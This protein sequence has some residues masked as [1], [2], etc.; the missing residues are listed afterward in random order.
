MCD[1][2]YDPGRPKFIGHGNGVIFYID[3]QIITSSFSSAALGL[4]LLTFAAALHDRS[5]GL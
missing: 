4:V 1:E 2:K 3:A 5:F